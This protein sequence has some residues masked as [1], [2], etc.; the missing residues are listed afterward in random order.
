M[1]LEEIR[2]RSSEY[3]NSLGHGDKETEL[4]ALAYTARIALRK[5]KQFED[6]DYFGAIVRRHAN[7]ILADRDIIKAYEGMRAS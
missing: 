5:L 1:T 6:A 3:F 2:I 4:L 7:L